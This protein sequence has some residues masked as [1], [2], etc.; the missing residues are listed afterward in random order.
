MAV[1]S[2]AKPLEGTNACSLILNAKDNVPSINPRDMQAHLEVSLPLLDRQ[3]ARLRKKIREH[4]DGLVKKQ[5]FHNGWRSY[6]PF[7][8]PPAPEITYEKDEQVAF[9][10][11][12]EP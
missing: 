2:Q 6:P 12:D 5:M 7:I 4:M 1:E 10:F 3:I 8:N 9:R 11:F